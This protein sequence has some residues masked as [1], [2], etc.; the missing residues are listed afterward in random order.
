MKDLRYHRDGD[1]E[2]H[3]EKAD[4]CISMILA[5]YLGTPGELNI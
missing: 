3:R 1:T 4:S 5:D 2:E